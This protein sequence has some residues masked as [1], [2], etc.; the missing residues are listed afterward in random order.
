MKFELVRLLALALSVWLIL[1]GNSFAQTQEHTISPR[2][3]DSYGDIYCE[4]AKARLDAL[5]IE[6][7]KMP[8]AKAYFIIYRGRKLPGRVLP[9]LTAHKSYLPDRGI[10]ASR[11]VTIEGGER[12][13]MLVEVWIVPS[14]ASPPSPTSE[15]QIKGQPNLTSVKYDEGWADLITIDGKLGITDDSDCPLRSLSLKDFANA[16]RS[17]PNSQGYFIIYTQFDKGAK[18]AQRV[19]SIVKKEMVKDYG[20]ASRQIQIIYGGHREYPAMELWIVPKGAPLPKPTPERRRK[21][22]ES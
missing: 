8:D 15:P 20:I 7:M 18:R 3:F 21:G 13:E 19:A 11:I 17:E 4:D 10:D 2:K 1:F 5:A 6:L 22:A 9:Y 12:E 14:G 16:L